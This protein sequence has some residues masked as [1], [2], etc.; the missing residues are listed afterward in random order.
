[1]Y[2]WRTTWKE[3]RSGKHGGYSFGPSKKESIAE[4]P[5]SELIAGDTEWITIELTEAGV[6]AALNKYASH[7]EKD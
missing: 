4:R 5:H 2:L 6:I 7:P 3:K 1:M